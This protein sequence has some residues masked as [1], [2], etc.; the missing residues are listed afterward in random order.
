MPVGDKAWARRIEKRL[1][2]GHEVPA[3]SR[4]FAEEVLGRQLLRGKVGQRPDAADRQAG[5]DSFSS[6][7]FVQL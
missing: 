3:I 1:S 2:D 7:R 6:E 4:R 5:D